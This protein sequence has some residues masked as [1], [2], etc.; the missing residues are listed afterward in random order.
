[1]D[2]EP[3]WKFRSA[4]TLIELLAVIAVLAILASILLTAVSQTR[5][6]A[7]QIQCSNNVRQLGIGLRAFVTDNNQYP[8][9]CNPGYPQYPEHKKLWI[10]A[11]QNAEFSAGG[12][13]S[14]RIYF[15]QWLSAGVWK[16]PAA[17]RPANW[18]ISRVYNSYGY[19]WFGMSAKTDTN[20]LGIGGHHPWIYPD[21]LPAPPV[22]ESE[23]VS[24]SDTI[25]IG[26]GFCGGNGV[27]VDGRWLLWRTGGVT[28]F[29]GSTRRSYAR[30]QGRANVVFCD[31]H[32][33]SPTLKFLFEDTND[34]ALICWNRDH[35]PH[36]EF[37]G[38]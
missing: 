7:L 5:S 10:V 24:P 29:L 33:E 34:A 26:D 6:R 21:L 22:S 9:F 12:N 11:L 38:P 16:C 19:N 20:T 18:P 36:R 23:V 13:S 14:N 2:S 4:F 30:H 17:N 37:L 28:N 32:V 3:N 31:G 1:V 25:A 27:I 35:L 15:S 8:L